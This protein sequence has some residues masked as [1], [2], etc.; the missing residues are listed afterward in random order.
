LLQEVD[1]QQERFDDAREQMET[2][3]QQLEEARESVDLQEESF[4]EV[5]DAA[6]QAFDQWLVRH[7]EIFSMEPEEIAAARKALTDLYGTSWSDVLDPVESAIQRA[8]S[9]LN[10]NEA[11]L[12]H[13][14]KQLNEELK[15]LEVELKSWR[16]QREPEPE[17][18]ADTQQARAQLRQQKIPFQPFYNLIEFANHLDD[19]QKE[20][21]EAALLHMGLLDALVVPQGYRNQL[22]L[23]HD[24]ILKPQSISHEQSLADVLEAVAVEGFNAQE[25]TTL[26]RSIPFDRFDSEAN[27][28]Y[29]NS[30]GRYQNGPIR[31]HAPREVAAVF[32]G[33]QAREA[34]RQRRIAEL[35]QEIETQTAARDNL[36]NELDFCRSSKTQ[37][38]QTRDSFPAEKPVMAAFRLLESAR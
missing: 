2:F 8:M 22:K 27:T 10:Q 30:T 16:E 17:R 3:K 37:L 35:E 18:H 7:Q 28:T 19:G 21:I 25:I 9:I 4:A 31:G 23:E 36:Q 11:Q 24:R 5:K 13:R 15:R 14:I 20:R 38:R 1:R 12:Q 29:V 6:C 33:Q 34:F 26:L 32:I